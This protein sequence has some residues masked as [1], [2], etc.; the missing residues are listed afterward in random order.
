MK[1]KN[2][3]RNRLVDI[4][5]Y[6]L[7]VAF[8]F[9][10]PVSIIAHNGIR[11]LFSAEILSDALGEFVLG[12]DSLREQL[13]EEVFNSGWVEDRVTD[14]KPF[15]YLDHEDRLQIAEEIFPDEWI[16]AQ[17]EEG[18]ATAIE[19]LQTDDLDL[20]IY[21]DF[22]Q[23]KL[24]LFAGGSKSIA[25]ILVNSWPSCSRE[26]E[27]TMRGTLRSD[28]FHTLEFCKPGEELSIELIDRMDLA[29]QKYV[30]N[31]E[32]QVYLF[33]E[34]DELL[35]QDVLWMTKRNLLGLSLWLRWL[36]IAPFPMMGLIMALVI[37]SI[38]DMGRW[39]GIPLILGSMLGLLFLA[40]WQAT[41]PSLLGYY[42]P[43]AGE[44]D[45]IRS[46]VFPISARISRGAAA[47]SFLTLLI[48]VGLFGVTWAV[49]RTPQE[50]EISSHSPASNN[51]PG[52]SAVPS[53]GERNKVEGI[54]SPP[55]VKPFD[56]EGLSHKGED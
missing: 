23:I 8:I 16:V 11:V 24:N 32:S 34:N 38:K 21:L 56:P 18:I 1:S 19:W 53:Q 48:G 42:L 43:D 27:I 7:V 50:P 54:P 37:R 17:I 2:G 47:H 5:V 44:V 49:Y 45:S 40:V 55:P 30:R 41:I 13:L 12:R 35:S 52:G 51:D 6:L 28:V 10:L 20:R 4:A 15:H 9:A 3:P 39:W 46:I 14:R 22:E 31:I 36:R 33:G 26:Q 25:E 29:L